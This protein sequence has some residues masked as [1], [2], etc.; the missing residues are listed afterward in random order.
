MGVSVSFDHSV[1]PSGHDGV[2]EAGRVGDAE[3]G[4]AARARHAGGTP[5]SWRLLPASVASSQWGRSWSTREDG[6]GRG[7][8]G[9]QRPSHQAAGTTRD[10]EMIASHQPRYLDS[11]PGPNA[12]PTVRPGRA[13]RWITPRG[14][15]LLPRPLS[16]LRKIALVVIR[17]LG[18]SAT[19][20]SPG[21]C[22]PRA[23]GSLLPA[24][25]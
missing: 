18:G 8:L 11:E 7:R 17:G 14:S 13:T 25:D 24:V 2:R 4:G 9:A 6:G 5:G 1:T 20:P 16:R 19:R 21:D 22:A 23:L 12:T 10:P 15:D 3:R